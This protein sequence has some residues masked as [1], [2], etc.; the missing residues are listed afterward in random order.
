MIIRVFDSGSSSNFYQIISSNGNKLFLEA[1]LSIKNILL[2]V[3]SFVGVQGCLISH[4]TSEDLLYHLDHS[5]SMHEL[6]KRNIRCY[7][8]HNLLPNKKFTLGEFEIIAVP[9]PHGNV[10]C[11]SFIIRNTFENKILCFITDTSSV[12]LTTKK[13]LDLAM[14]ET[15]WQENVINERIANGETD[16]HN[17]ESHLELGKA[18]DW[19]NSLSQKPKNVMAIH[20]SK[21][22]CNP[23]DVLNALTKVVE[24]S[25]IAKKGLE[26]EI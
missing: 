9:T 20:L 17:Y 19:L 12:S 26:I 7:G 3:D 10:D 8:V 2:K 16:L 14:I 11:Y 5:R 1:G 23:T 25:Y 24:N 15:N 6:E 4:G 18:I 13:C 21:Q 22:N